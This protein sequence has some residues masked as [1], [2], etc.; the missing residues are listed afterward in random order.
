MP[1]V[2]LTS[3]SRLDSDASTTS[4][5]RVRRVATAAGVTALLWLAPLDLPPAAHRAV[6]I[7]AG[8]IVAWATEALPHV[9]ASLLG[10]VLIGLAGAA[11]W[12]V[13]A[14]GFANE[15]TWFLMGALVIGAAASAT[16][17]AQR[18]AFA[19]VL[20][21]DGSYSRVLLAL[22]VTTFLLTFLVPS[23]IARVAVLAAI[24]A[25]LVDTTGLGRRSP[26]ARGLM[27]GVT[28]AATMF[29]KMVLGGAASILAAG[30]IETV[31]GIRVSYSGWLLA[32]LPCAL[33]TILVCWRAV[34][35][36]YPDSALDG[37]GR[38]R[39]AEEAGAPGAWSARERRAAWLLGCA[40]ALWFTDVLHGLRPAWVAIATALAAVS[41][42]VGV[43]DTGD[44]RRL[45]AGVVVFTAAAIGMTNVLGASGGLSWLTDHM[46]TWITPLVRGPVA[47]AQ[48]LYWTA[49]LYHFLLGSETS[50]ISATLP[51]VLVFAKD[52]GLPILP[53][54]LVW[55]FGSAGKLFAYQGSVLMVGY[56]YGCFDARDL[57]KVGALLTLVEAAILAAIVALYWPLLGM[58]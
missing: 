13:V 54:G 35:W 46:V 19:M 8:L 34:L 7:S 3:D 10:L 47:T 6:A 43:L 29:D 24:V 1:G 38:R 36:L 11:P 40:V 14:S 44:L 23:G 5:I 58:A 53:V 25:G 48:A 37:V 31:G 9:A 51:A 18:L 2:T 45:R 50:M 49:F 32:F 28:Y 22:L 33:L 21:T 56:A 16:G 57:L 17:I 26:A 4:T 52:S 55:T 12:S 42:G 27:I 15:A 30:L 20:R 39:L 41:P